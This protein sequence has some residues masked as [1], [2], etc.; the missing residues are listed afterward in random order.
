M[1]PRSNSLYIISD[2]YFLDFP[3]PYLKRND[4]E[5]RP[6]CFCIP[7]SIS[8]LFWM[9]P[10]SRR[11]AKYEDKIN[12][13]KAENKPCNICHVIPLA[14]GKS[15]FVTGDVFPVTSKYID[16]EYTISGQPVMLLDKTDIKAIKTKAKAILAITRKGIIFN[17]KQPGI[18][19]IEAQLIEM[20]TKK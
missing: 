8:G 5:N 13:R 12:K 15:A 2:Q 20:L 9:V 14:G 4:E 11:I 16:R 17:Q 1:L 10:M 19:S 3:D 6:A 18:L 7:G